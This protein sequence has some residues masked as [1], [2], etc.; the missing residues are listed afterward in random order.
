[1]CRSGV[2]HAFA[3]GNDVVV[4]WIHECLA[5][6]ETTDCAAGTPGFC[7]EGAAV[8]GSEASQARAL[9]EVVDVLAV[10]RSLGMV[11]TSND[12]VMYAV[13]QRNGVVRP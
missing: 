4:A 7:G 5:D 3:V 8:Q 6:A 9:M 2:G 11:D 1:M 13:Q 12:V 10:K